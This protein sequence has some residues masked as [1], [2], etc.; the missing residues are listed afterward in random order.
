[1]FILCLAFKSSIPSELY[2]KCG[3]QNRTK[4]IDVS[5]V[6][7]MFGT[8]LC[9]SLPGLHAFT[10]CDSVSAFAGKGKLAPLKIVKKHRKF[11][12]LFEQLGMEWQLSDQDF[13]LLQEFTCLLYSVNSGTSDVNDLRYRLF[14]TRK[15]ELDSNQ[16]PP[17]GDC[18]KLHSSR[19][20]Y[21][22]AIW[23]R[24]LEACP[25][26]PSAVGHGWVQEEDGLKIKWMSGE[27]APKAVLEFL[28]C[29]CL[30]T[31]QPLNCSC[32]SNG[33]K[34]TDKCR[35]R[36]CGNRNEEDVFDWIDPSLDEDDDE[37]S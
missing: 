7:R 22:A 12:V 24:S 16:L 8:Q 20:N 36:E 26:V 17:C 13:A 3:T 35:L 31:C 21:Q 14:C 37:D 15:D 19:A 25:V 29:S 1:M 2:V 34:C 10:G 11:Q 27:P 5:D 33:L 30:R 28:S 4:Y 32:C 6:V 18:L 23:R 9:K